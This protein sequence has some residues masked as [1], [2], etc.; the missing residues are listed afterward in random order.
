MSGTR[1]SEEQP[2]RDF[3]SALFEQYKDRYHDEV[4][5]SISF[6]GKEVNFFTRAKLRYLLSLAEEYFSDLSTLR[7]LDV[8]CGIGLTDRHLVSHVGELHGVDL[9]S[10]VIDRAAQT[11]PSAH[12]HTYDGQRV[13]FSENSFDLTFAICVLHHVPPSRQ[14]SLTTEMARVTRPGGMVAIF[15]HNPFNPLTRFAVFRCSFD[16]DA[17]LVRPKKVRDILKSAGLKSIKTAYTIAVPFDGPFWY[18][19]DRILGAVPLGTQ[20]YIAGIK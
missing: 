11:V 7:V 13:P 4:Q 15:E 14:L 12:Y 17:A 3:N 18:R 5:R 16:R 6:F 20:Y 19:L 9:T 10:G 8:G 2:S 1:D